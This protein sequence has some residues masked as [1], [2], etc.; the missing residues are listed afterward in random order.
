MGVSFLQPDLIGFRLTAD[1]LISSSGYV[2]EDILIGFGIL[3]VNW[4][5]L[6]ALRSV[7]S[8]AISG[9]DEVD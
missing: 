9:Y 7:W 8:A 3:A 6:A 2:V 4:S 1:P 5:H